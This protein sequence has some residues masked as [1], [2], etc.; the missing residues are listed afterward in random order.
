MMCPSD[1][2]CDS[3][4][5]EAP[6]AAL[7][8]HGI[9]RQI[10]CPKQQQHTIDCEGGT[11]ETILAIEYG[12]GDYIGRQPGTKQHV[13]IETHRKMQQADNNEGH[14]TQSENPPEHG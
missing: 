10:G 2:S 8:H 1:Q 11:V 9:S 14:R 6:E 3:C 12:V 4:C 5:K 13:G 7:Q